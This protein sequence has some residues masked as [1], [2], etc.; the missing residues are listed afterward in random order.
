MTEIKLVPNVT[1]LQTVTTLDI[2]T[3]RVLQAALDCE[4]PLQHA[5]V[6][7]VTSEGNL[8]FGS[9][10]ADGGDVLWWIE[11]AKL[12]LLSGDADD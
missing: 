6:I 1:V 7:G 3:E 9:S 12:A 5:V 4:E 2:P 8:Y 11:K 10:M